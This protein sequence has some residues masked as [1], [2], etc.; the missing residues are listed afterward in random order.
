ME[1]ADQCVALP[2]GL[3]LKETSVLTQ[4]RPKARASQGT[5]VYLCTST[6]AEHDGILLLTFCLPKGR[7]KL[8]AR[9]NSP[10]RKD[11]EASV[12]VDPWFF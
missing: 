8:T 1:F 2:R 10:S 3:D 7:C 12:D 9:V 6:S 5:S 4:S 11:Y